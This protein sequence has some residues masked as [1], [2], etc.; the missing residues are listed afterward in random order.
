MTIHIIIVYHNSSNAV[1]VVPSTYSGRLHVSTERALG[2]DESE[3]T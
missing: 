3:N 1:T 2:R